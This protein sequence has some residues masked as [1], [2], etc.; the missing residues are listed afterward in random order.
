ME[1]K[2]IEKKQN[3]LL[4]RTELV[5][6]LDAK[7]PTPKEEDIKKEVIKKE[8]IAEEKNPVEIKGIY[9]KFGT[10]KAVVHAY[11]YSSPESLERLKKKKK[12]KKEEKKK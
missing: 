6:E 10:T 4:E 8:K 12:K 5:F 3:P 11:I 1:L 2:L 7:G 9:P